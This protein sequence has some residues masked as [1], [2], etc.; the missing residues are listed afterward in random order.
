[1]PLESSRTRLLM[2]M[3]VLRRNCSA[4]ARL[5]RVC[6][7]ATSSSAW[8]T[9]NHPGN[10]ATSAM[11]ETS[12]ISS[13]RR[14]RGSKPNTRSSPSKLVRPRI[15]FRAVVLPAPLGP[16]RPTMRPGATEKLTSAN[17]GVEWYDF[18]RPRASITFVITLSWRGGVWRRGRS[19]P[20]TQ[21]V[22]RRQAQPLNGGVDLRPLLLEEALPLVLHQGIARPAADEHPQPSPLFHQLLINELLVALQDG[23]WVQSEF[24]CHVPDRRQRIAFLQHTFQNHRDHPVPQLPVNRQ[25]V[26]PL[27][28][29]QVLCTLC[30]RRLAD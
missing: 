15:A 23:E 3:S 27:R 29:H 9:R 21:Q 26:I 25:A 6:T 30:D 11:N 13:S 24:R 28:I 18:F 8:P 20:V 7:P 17:A 12:R 4:R 14:E 10:T 19:R 1:M 16:M 5:K 22:G 2:R